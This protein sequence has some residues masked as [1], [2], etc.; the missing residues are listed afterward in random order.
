MS[1]WCFYLHSAPTTP[2]MMIK[3]DRLSIERKSSWEIPGIC[4]KMAVHVKHSVMPRYRLPGGG[5]VVETAVV[6][7]TGC[8]SRVGLLLGF[9]DQ[10]V[11]G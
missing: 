1:Q 10:Q 8:T 9:A 7:Q 5:G 2:E 4:A 11:K 6:L 3:I